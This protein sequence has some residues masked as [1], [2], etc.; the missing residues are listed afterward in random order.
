MIGTDFYATQ[1]L[2]FAVPLGTLALVILFGFFQR[3]PS[4]R[5]QRDLEGRAEQ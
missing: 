3:R 4:R 2:T 5:A 1:T